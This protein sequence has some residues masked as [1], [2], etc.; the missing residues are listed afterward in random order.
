VEHLLSD[1][2]DVTVQ[3]NLLWT[4]LSCLEGVISGLVTPLH[5]QVRRCERTYNDAIRLHYLVGFRAEREARVQ[6]GFDPQPA[7]K[8]KARSTGVDF[9]GRRLRAQTTGTLPEEEELEET[10]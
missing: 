7:E 3:L 4:R 10:G 2:Y 8:R 6:L 9:A 1:T 5:V